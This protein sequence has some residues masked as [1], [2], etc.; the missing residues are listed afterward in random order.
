MSGP[1]ANELAYGGGSGDPIDGYSGIA[2]KF[3]EGGRRQ[4]TE[5]PVDPAGVETQCA[6]PLL[7]LSDIVASDHGGSA[8]QETVTQSS[9]CFDQRRPGLWTTDAVDPETAPMLEGLD[10]CSGAV[11]EPAL[12]V[13]GAGQAEGVEPGLYV[14]HRCS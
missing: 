10:R 1:E 4:V 8:V 13:D 5:D 11:A 9:A 2:L 12:S 6:Q 7:Q 14:G 3:A